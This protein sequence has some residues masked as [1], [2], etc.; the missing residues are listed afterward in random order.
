MLLE[1]IMSNTLLILISFCHEWDAKSNIKY[2]KNLSGCGILII[3]D[4]MMFRLFTF[5]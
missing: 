2:I 1:F 5:F 4:L 3:I